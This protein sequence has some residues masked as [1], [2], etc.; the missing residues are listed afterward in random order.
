[1]V[2]TAAPSLALTSEVHHVANRSILG[3]IFTKTL[4]D[5]IATDHGV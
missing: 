3:I 4:D 5:P 1:V 2:W